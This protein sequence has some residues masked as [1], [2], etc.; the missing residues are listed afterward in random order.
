MNSYGFN[1][2]KSR[3]MLA[4]SKINMAYIV[5]REDGGHQANVKIHI[6]RIEACEDYRA[7]IN[8]VKEM[9]A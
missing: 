9:A 4:W 2:N 6:N 3:I 7:R 8:F 1:G 5:W